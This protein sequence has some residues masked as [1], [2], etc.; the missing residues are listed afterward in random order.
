MGHLLSLKKVNSYL[1]ILFPFY[2]AKITKNF[3]MVSA[4]FDERLK[5]YAPLHY[6]S[7]EQRPYDK[8]IP[9]TVFVHCASWKLKIIVKFFGT[10]SK[11][12]GPFQVHRTAGIKLR[13]FGKVYIASVTIFS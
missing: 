10:R 5:M 3:D 4:P 13:I 1:K 9:F 11:F 7:K 6:H 2:V 12:R 8:L